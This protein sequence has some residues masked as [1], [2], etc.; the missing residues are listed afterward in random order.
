[1][2]PFCDQRMMRSIEKCVS[3]SRIIS[4]NNVNFS[5]AESFKEI[6][7]I[8]NNEYIYNPNIDVIDNLCAY[9]DLELSNYIKNFNLVKPLE[10]K[11]QIKLLSFEVNSNMVKNNFTTN[12]AQIC[13]HILD[14]IP[15]GMSAHKKKQMRKKI[16]QIDND[17]AIV[18]AK[19]DKYLES[20]PEVSI[21]HKFANIWI[22][23][24]TEYLLHLTSFKYLITLIKYVEL[25]SIHL[26]NAE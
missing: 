2:D 12:D 20:L 25:K 1:M 22:F 8:I 19:L 7:K 11:G 13:A 18:Q 16:K 14:N 3:I 21:E 24:E 23:T 6:F 15:D 17:R 5:T 4:F 10:L 26:K 9:Y